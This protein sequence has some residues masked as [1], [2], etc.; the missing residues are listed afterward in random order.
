VI[1]VKE[2]SK[3][4]YKDLHCEILALS[5]I[6]ASGGKLLVELQE[7]PRF[8]QFS[9][10]STGV[11]KGIEYSFA[12]VYAHVYEYANMLN[13]DKSTQIIS[14]LPLYHDMGLIACLMLPLITRH[15]VHLISAFEWIQ[16]PEILFSDAQKLKSTHVWMPNFAFK[17]LT[18]K[19]PSGKYSL[20]SFKCMSS[21]AEPVDYRVV[22]GFF[23]KFEGDGLKTDCLSSTY[24]MAENIFAMSHC[25]FNLNDDSWY[26][27]LSNKE[28]L[29][30]NVD[31]SEN[32]RRYV[33]SCG[34]RMPSVDVQINA[35]SNGIGDI[36][37]RSP[38]TANQY[39]NMDI[40]ILD[41]N[42]FF[43]TNDQGF[44]YGEELFVVGRATDMIIQNGINIYPQDIENVVNSICGVYPGRNVCFGL[45]NDET[46]TEDIVILAEQKN[47][48]DVSALIYN[49]YSSVEGRLGFV[50]SVVK[51]LP[52]M[53]LRKTSSGKISRR[54]NRQKFQGYL[55]KQIHI[56]G[57]SHVYAFNA[58]DELY[59][60]DTTA[61][62]VFLK[63]IPIVSSENILCFPKWDELVGYLENV[64]D[65]SLIALLIGEQD[66]RTVIPW[67]C[68][69][70]H[71]NQVQ[72]VSWVIEKYNG[73]VA[74]LQNM[75]PELTYIWILPPPPGEGLKP[76]PRFVNS[77]ELTDEVYYHFSADQSTRRCIAKQFQKTLCNK[78][79]LP[80]I[81]IWEQIVSSID[82]ELLD[83]YRRDGSHIQ[84]VKLL[85][86]CKLEALSGYIVG[87]AKIAE[88]S[89]E[90]QKLDR[91]NVAK[92]LS[93]LIKL[94]FGHYLD[95]GDE[96]TLVLSSMDIVTLFGLLQ[97]KYHV[98]LPSTWMDKTQIQ[99]FDSFC[100]WV[101]GCSG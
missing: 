37:I 68:R 45:Y 7:E 60:Q 62:N 9:S 13:L 51:I 2:S 95:M 38:F 4:F 5:E 17:L 46:G 6:E 92:E 70:K 99:Y 31:T 42:G 40:Q 65:G 8:L 56:I 55:E 69:H 85:Y 90:R 83:K 44:L 91:D 93:Q 98:D 87:K 71:M 76:H 36:C 33:V 22:R 10:G 52:H 11:P 24:A 77:E 15:P 12:D 88:Q 20:S 18:D 47:C 94:N 3:S 58:S 84:N 50:P 101:L 43:N 34:C 54:L 23:N 1:V 27:K 89:T 30:G 32:G 14:W 66:I 26:L 72:A 100:E 16:K 81:D 41:E 80:V 97:K 63:Q 57:C 86:E 59:N 48:D 82:L 53:W 67:L 64:P 25:S 39:H 35:P 73:L 79:E 19:V 21:C 78:L 96:L 61:E 28:F 75:Y 49:I 74:K 29:S